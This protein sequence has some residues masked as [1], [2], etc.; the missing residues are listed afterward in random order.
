M[1]SALIH[2]IPQE[3]AV[4]ANTWS[5]STNT[6][7]RKVRQAIAVCSREKRFDHSVDE[8]LDNVETVHKLGSND[9]WQIVRDRRE[10]EA[11][12]CRWSES[13]KV[14]SQRDEVVQALVLPWDGEL[15]AGQDQVCDIGAGR[16][17]GVRSLAAKP[18]PWEGLVEVEGGDVCEVGVERI[19]PVWQ[20]AEDED[21]LCGGNG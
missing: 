17:Q 18:V 20:C 7:I 4:G 12:R 6:R 14:S 16:L 2:A 19:G 3:V 9:T 13:S 21:T 1:C 15:G 11:S 8:T 5:T 10:E